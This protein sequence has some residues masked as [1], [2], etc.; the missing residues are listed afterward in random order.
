MATIFLSD[1]ERRR[2][3]EGWSVQVGENLISPQT[4]TSANIETELEELKITCYNCGKRINKGKRWYHAD[5]DDLVCLDCAEELEHTDTAYAGQ[6]VSKMPTEINLD[7]M[8]KKTPFYFTDED[9]AMQKNTHLT[10]D[11]EIGIILD[12]RR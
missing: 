5:Q 9:R 12:R 7:R 2:L 8:V 3:F 10:T 11:A 4:P 1:W 6:S